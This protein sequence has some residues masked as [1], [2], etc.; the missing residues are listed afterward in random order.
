LSAGLGAADATTARLAGSSSAPQRPGSGRSDR[1][2]PRYS[3]CSTGIADAGRQDK[4][5]GYDPARPAH[6]KDTAEHPV[7]LGPISQLAGI[8][9]ST[10]PIRFDRDRI[11]AGAL[12]E[13]CERSSI[14]YSF[15]S[16][17][18]SEFDI[19]RPSQGS[20]E[21]TIR[22]GKLAV[23]LETRVFSVDDQPMHVTGTKYAI[24]ELL[25]PQGY[26]PH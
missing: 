15:G 9:S 21:A 16:G 20:P 7:D 14:T 22:T 19:V 11:G 17:S 24:L 25:S 3:G 13:P 18:L 12:A 10:S 23:N 8:A 5:A 1:A 26:H 4:Q 6:Q 2:L